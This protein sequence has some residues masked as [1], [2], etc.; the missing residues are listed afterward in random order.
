MGAMKS[1]TS[2]VRTAIAT[3]TISKTSRPPMAARIRQNRRISDCSAASSEPG[4]VREANGVRAPASQRWPAT[5]D[6]PLTNGALGAGAVREPART[7]RCSRYN[8]RRIPTASRDKV[9]SAQG[10]VELLQCR[11]AGN[12]F[13]LAQLAQRRVDGVQ[14]RMHV[15]CVA[16]QIQKAGDD[17]ARSMALLKE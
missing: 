16:V 9:A 1:L 3:A 5:Q 11:G 7:G 15:A 14:R 8:R 4:P 2:I 13:L 12:Q 17:L 6:L 10:S